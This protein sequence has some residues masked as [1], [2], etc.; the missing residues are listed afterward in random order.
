MH[1]R[2]SSPS[3]G[4]ELALLRASLGIYGVLSHVVTER[5]HSPVPAQRGARR[6]SIPS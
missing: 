5:M 2:R 3:G 6:A 4:A 1:A